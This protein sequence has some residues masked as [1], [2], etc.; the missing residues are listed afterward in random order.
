MI[1]DSGN[2]LLQYRDSDIMQSISMR[3]SY[4]LDTSL[5]NVFGPSR[6]ELNK[7]SLS[8]GVYID[9]TVQ[10]FCTRRGW[11][12]NFGFTLLPILYVHQMVNMLPP[13]STKRSLFS[14]RLERGLTSVF[15]KHINWYCIKLINSFFTVTL[16]IHLTPGNYT[17]SL[18]S[19]TKTQRK[20]WKH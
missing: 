1:L 11:Q 4:D 16:Y 9:K 19:P 17:N 15:L 10:E 3:P 2:T 20:I 8:V 12:N 13:T 6:I 14:L 5:H 7:T 18:L